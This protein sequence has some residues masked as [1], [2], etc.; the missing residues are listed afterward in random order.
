MWYHDEKI[1]SIEIP[2]EDIIID[3]KLNSFSIA[4]FCD[5]NGNLYYPKYP[6]VFYDAF[7]SKIKDDDEFMLDLIGIA[8]DL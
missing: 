7:N 1:A 2:V 6:T 3:I 5:D 8:I 4:Y